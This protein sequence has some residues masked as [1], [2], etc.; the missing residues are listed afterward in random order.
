MM[1]NYSAKLRDIYYAPK[2][3]INL[4]GKT[5][6]FTDGI[7]T[8]LSKY[9]AE[10]LLRKRIVDS[11]AEGEDIQRLSYVTAPDVPVPS[12]EPA[13]E[14]APE[15]EPTPEPEPEPEPDAPEDEETDSEY[16]REELEALY[17]EHGTW[18][19]VASYLDVS[20]A[21]LKKYR[22]AVGL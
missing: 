6:R 22:D 17:E 19:S 2:K 13:T 11:I 1:E 7:A 15:P 4:Y 20:T 16:T 3:I 21:T 10:T 12:P 14:P 18:T 8:G 9:Q 5:I